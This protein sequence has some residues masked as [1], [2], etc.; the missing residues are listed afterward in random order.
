[1]ALEKFLVKT[2]EKYEWINLI[3]EYFNIGANDSINYKY[4]NDGSEIVHLLDND[5][6]QD[7]HLARNLN[8]FM[9]IEKNQLWIYFKK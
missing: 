1:M 3:H 9:N 2:S 4:F 6:V 5:D 7:E 8:I